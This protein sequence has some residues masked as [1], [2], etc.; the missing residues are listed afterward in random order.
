M[1]IVPWQD[2]PEML[3]NDGEPKVRMSDG[4]VEEGDG[5]D[6]EHRG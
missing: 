6:G 4:E 2:E 1:L 5:N 3:M